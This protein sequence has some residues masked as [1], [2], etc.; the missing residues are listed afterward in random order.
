M[1]EGL[2]MKYFVLNPN[3]A[4]PYGEA[5]LAALAAYSPAIAATNPELAQD[6][7]VWIAD[8]KLRAKEPQP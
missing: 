3:K 5:S 1:S 6:L 7:L 4:G 2:Q 8:I